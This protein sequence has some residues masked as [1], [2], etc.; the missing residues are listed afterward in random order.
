[1]KYK[2]LRVEELHSLEKEFISFLASA[3]ITAQ[4]W[5]L[6][7]KQELHKAEELI[8][9]FSDVVY[10]KVMRNIKYVEYRD[11]KTLNIYHCGNDTIQLIG[12]R[13]S[14][15]S[16]INLMSEN[17]LDQWQQNHDAGVSIVRS[18]KKYLTTR[19]EEVFALLQN[20][21]T[22]TTEKYFLLLANLP[23]S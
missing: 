18:Q 7:K 5:E 11:D 6:M 21:C 13:V 4:D 17:I 14:A 23:D 1:M 19:E 2:R 9:V 8:E 15:N 3:Q 12:L 22:V 16:P 10:D 20:G